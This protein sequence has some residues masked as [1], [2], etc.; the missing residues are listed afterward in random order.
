MKDLLASCLLHLTECVR[1]TVENSVGCSNL[2]TFLI[3]LRLG[4]TQPTLSGCCEG[5]SCKVLGYISGHPHTFN[6]P[7]IQYY[8]KNHRCMCIY[9]NSF[10]GFCVVGRDRGQNFTFISHKKRSGRR[11]H[12]ENILHTLTL[13]IIT[14]EYKGIRSWFFACTLYLPW[15]FARL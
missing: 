15:I 3:D 1:Q 10:Y 7:T 9:Q 8:W 12:Q 4:F 11:R 5:N 2:K 14:F 13:S 6:I